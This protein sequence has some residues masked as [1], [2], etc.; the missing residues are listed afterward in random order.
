MQQFFKMLV[1]NQMLQNGDAHLKNFGLLYSHAQDVWLAPAYDV[2]STTAYVRQDQAALTLQGC[3][4]W[5]PREGMLRFAVQHCDLTQH[6][7]EQLYAECEQAKQ[8][9]H[10]EIAH[11]PAAMQSTEAR[12][13]QTHLLG[14]LGA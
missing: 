2:I 8:R 13:L 14:L 12:A 4:R 10:A 6:K 11:S 9:S 1:C 3:R 5:W 7:S